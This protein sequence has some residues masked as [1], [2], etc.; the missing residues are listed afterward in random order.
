MRVVE[1]VEIQPH[2]LGQVAQGA[3]GTLSPW[4]ATSTSRHWATYQSS[5]WW[6]AAVKTFDIAL[7]YGLKQGRDSWNGG[8]S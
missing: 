3:S 7:R 4:L 1:L 2:G 8:G 5:S 6:T